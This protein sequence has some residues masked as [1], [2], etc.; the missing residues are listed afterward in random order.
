MII[1]APIQFIPRILGKILRIRHVRINVVQAHRAEVMGYVA[2]ARGFA[3]A[4][5]TVASCVLVCAA[6][7]VVGGLV[8]LLARVQEFAVDL[9]VERGGRVGVHFG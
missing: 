4:D 9:C 6:F 1:K 5:E 8:P 3:V 2:S 7:G